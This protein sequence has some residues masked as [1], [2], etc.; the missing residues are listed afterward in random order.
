MT[1]KNLKT[2]VVLA[3]V[4]VSLS[5][6]AFLQRLTRP[7]P[8]TE[9]ISLSGP[10]VAPRNEI[11]S[12]SGPRVATPHL[13][14]PQITVMEPM[15]VSVVPGAQAYGAYCAECH[16]AD[17]RGHGYQAPRLL[18]KPTDLT[19]LSLNG[20]GTFP[21]QRVIETVQAGPGDYHRAIL[22]GFSGALEG[23]LVEFVSDSG[24]AILAPRGLVEVLAYLESLQV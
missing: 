3:V 13:V 5:G 4:L 18:H 19:T 2:G 22:T 9:I 23:P 8:S 17:A 16:G 10:G 24:D 1:F 6:C 12:L 14:T 21:A 15:T 7:A 20:D 11:I